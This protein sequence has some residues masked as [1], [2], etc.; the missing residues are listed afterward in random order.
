MRLIVPSSKERNLLIAKGQ[1]YYIHIITIFTSGPS[2]EAHFYRTSEP[3]VANF[4]PQGCNW[5]PG[6]KLS[7]T[8]EVKNGPLELVLSVSYGRYFGDKT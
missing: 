1:C 8:G 7:P 4:N 3:S 2:P 5:L 6:V